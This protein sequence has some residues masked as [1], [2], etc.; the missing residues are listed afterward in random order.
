MS[1]FIISAFADEIS[2]SL[3]D[4][5]R[6]LKENQI[7]HI[8]VRGVNGKN[9]SEFTLEEAQEYKQLLAAN[10][11]DVSSI[12]SPIGKVKL[13]DNFEEQFLLFRHILK[14]ATILESPYVRI[15]S[16]FM[17][18]NVEVNQYFVEV[19]DRLR[20]LMMIAADF[21]KITILHEN[22]KEIFGDTPERCLK[23]FEAINTSQFKLAF[24]P[25]NFVQCD[26][27][28]YQDAFRLLKDRIA[29]VH[30]KDAR[31][32]DHNVV[33]AGYGDGQLKEILTDLIRMNYFGFI[34][35]EP[36]LSLFNGFNQLEHGKIEL[37]ENDNVA[38]FNLASS[39]LKEM[40]VNEL[41]QEWV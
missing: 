39:A 33:P 11:I 38:K 17:A 25:A 2:D 14:I 9:V 5:I 27:V 19:V 30:V 1:H 34:S 15:F 28:V 40:V 13:T 24:D 23:L 7:S 41:N 21:P 26:V 4:Q 31:F 16:F 37:K 12:G 20:K 6:V 35:I 8:E 22:E 32:I 29:Y 3:E 36:H 18:P 10:K